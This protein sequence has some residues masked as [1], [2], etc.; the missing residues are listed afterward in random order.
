MCM[1]I[2]PNLNKRKFRNILTYLVVVCSVQSNL[3][4][5]DFAVLCCVDCAFCV[6]CAIVVNFSKWSSHYACVCVRVRARLCVLNVLLQYSVDFIVLIVLFCAMLILICYWLDCI[7]SFYVWLSFLFFSFI[8]M[9]W[10]ITIPFVSIY[11]HTKV[12]LELM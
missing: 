10:I 3:L 5:I 4:Y 1:V 11:K 9:L 8:K 12:L 2:F 7:G 6:N